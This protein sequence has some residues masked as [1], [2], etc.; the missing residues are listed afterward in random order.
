MA[1][2]MYIDG[3]PKR[4]T[5]G[6]GPNYIKESLLKGMTGGRKNERRLRKQRNLAKTSQARPTWVGYER[7]RFVQLFVRYLLSSLIHN[8]C[9]PVPRRIVDPSLV[10]GANIEQSAV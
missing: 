6:C 8:C 3:D 7:V 9:K 5:I 10:S 2:G 4:M 1:K